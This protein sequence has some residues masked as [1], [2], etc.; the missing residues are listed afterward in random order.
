MELFKEID[1]IIELSD[2]VLIAIDGNSGTG[3]T[4]LASRIGS[5]YD[6]NVFTMDSF[7][8]QPAQ[9]TAERLQQPGGNVDYLRFEEE[10]LRPLSAGEAFKY[11]PYDCFRQTL[12][13]E[14][15]V[16]P[17]GINIIEGVYSMHPNFSEIYDLSVFLKADKN[18]QLK[19]LRERD[20]Q[21]YSRYVEQWIPM[22]NKYFDTFNIMDQCDIVI[23]TTLEPLLL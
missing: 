14:I 1:E 20:A 19:R 12:A 7:F 18:E 8:L 17:K 23:D 9:R 22:E 3:K 16:L 13:E 10:V 6:C 15:N 2:N 11:S 4:S 21:K 5:M